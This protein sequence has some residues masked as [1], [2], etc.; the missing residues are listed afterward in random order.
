[1]KKRL[2]NILNLKEMRKLVLSNFLTFLLLI[3]I[4]PSSAET[5]AQDRISLNVQ[6]ESLKNVIK[7][8]Q[9]QTKLRFLYSSQDVENIVVV[10]VKVKNA[11]L[12]DVLNIVLKDSKLVW[13][14]EDNIVYIKLSPAVSSQI[15]T[16]RVK[17]VV[18]D[19]D[20]NMLPGVS[21][22]IKGTLLGAVTN[23]DGEFSILIPKDRV[24]SL[25]FSFIGMETVEVL[26]KGQKELNITLKEKA[27]EI[28]D[29]IV[30]GIFKRKAESYTGAS[31]TISAEELKRVGNQN[32]LSSLKNLDPSLYI[33]DNLDMG[34]DPNALPDMKIRGTTSFPSTSTNSFKGNYA[35]KPNQPLFILD[36]FETTVENI[37]DLDMN[38]VSTVTILKDA[39]AKALYGSKAANGVVIIETKRLLGN[40]P[41]VTYVG[42]VDIEA[43]DLSSYNLC[44]AEEKL[45]AELIEG[46]YSSGTFLEDK[47]D[48]LRLYN[49]RKKLIADGLD[50]YWLSK[51]LRT[52]VGQKHHV[53]IEVGDSNNLRS[54]IEFSYNNVAGVMK[55]SKRENIMGTANISYRVNKFIFRNIMSMTRNNSSES[56]YGNFYDYTLLNPYYRAYD[57]ETGKISRWLDD[58]AVEANPMYDALIGTKYEQSYFNFINNFYAEWNINENYKLTG[59]LGVNLKRSDSDDFLPANH[60]SFNNYRYASD[61]VKL[62]K[63]SYTYESGKSESITFDL[64]LNY[65]KTINKNYIFIN[66]GMSVSDKNT[67]AKRTVAI[68][69]PSNMGADLNFARQYADEVTP[70]SFS[71]LQRE[72][73]FLAVASYT[74]D[75][76][77][78][79]DFTYRLSASSLYGK[80][81]RWSPGWSLGMGWNL[82][83]EEFMDK[84][85]FVKQF[86]LR[87]S[88]GLTGNQNFDTNNAITTFQYYTDRNYKG[89]VG[90]YMSGLANTE[91]K[92][93]QRRDFDVGFDLKIFNL[94]AKFDYYVGNT[95]NMIADVSILTSTGFSSVKDNLGKVRNTG[96]ELS[97]SYNVIQHKDGFLN[98]FASATSEENKIIRL[99]DALRKYNETQMEIAEELGRSEPVLLYQD[100][101]SMNTIWAVPS[102]GID[103]I[104]GKEIYVK[105]DGSLTNEYSSLDLIAAGDA[106]P[107]YRGNFGFNADYKGFGLTMTCSFLAG[108]DMYNS[109]L[110]DR[111]E[112]IDIYK[113]VDKR[114]LEGRW[115]TPGVKT[116]FKKLQGINSSGEERTQATTRFVQNRDELSI[117]SISAY[118]EFNDKILRKTVFKILVSAKHFFELNNLNL[119]GLVSKRGNQP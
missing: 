95:K 34:S 38:R 8:I 86:K 39:A 92:L 13:E 99:S 1:M 74:Y 50:T 112:N 27:V 3:F 59:R 80:D 40:K 71:T 41:R 24:V 116:K 20:N 17:G 61:E 14:K 10:D 111:V 23:N 43:P 90:S 53:S 54:L 21:V 119:K 51:P 114:V 31:T 103:P 19:E 73:G 32:L 72:L 12:K 28:D 64:N 101:Q 81:N 67:N 85:K 42:S 29:V 98:L 109:T 7:N 15:S 60:S 94:T 83:K 9:N 45:Q 97:L 102:R 104:T 110:V 65:N 26:Y 84:F 36:G 46:V 30:T 6:K 89:Q 77:Y 11:D 22:L 52:G 33:Q 68:G 5:Y 63:G 70:E 25:V 79:F 76:K 44:N 4:I 88:I 117:A 69:F 106:D 100:G 82:H 107:K 87:G 35:N 62:K 56:P 48:N 55:D 91:L 108:G 115:Q 66:A 16:I 58:D 2:L 105:K 47:V 78:L 37:F 113:N 49:E 96:Y 57:K 18:K 75:N 118:Y 93:E